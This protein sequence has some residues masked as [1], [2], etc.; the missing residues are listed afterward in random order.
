[1]QEGLKKCQSLRGTTSSGSPGTAKKK[2]YHDFRS[3]LGWR[4]LSCWGT[5][6]NSL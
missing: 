6:V 4:R 5:F 2:K 3:W 1:M